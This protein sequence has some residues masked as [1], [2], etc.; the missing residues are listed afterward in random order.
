[1]FLGLKHISALCRL[2]IA[3][4]TGLSAFAGCMLASSRPSLY[5][6]SVAA[7]VL[8]LAAGASAL[9]QVQERDIDARM[10]RTRNRPLPAGLISPAHALAVA[11]VL[12]TAGSVMLAAFG[13]EPLILGIIALV[14][15]NG[16]YTPL[17]R[18]TAFAAV[19]GGFVGMIP[20]AIGWCAAGG[21]ISDPRL[22]AVGFFFFL[23]QVPHFWLQLLHHGEEY[24]SAGLPSLTARL[25]KSAVCRLTH[26]WICA[27]AVSAFL[28]PLYG[29]M[30]SQRI[31]VLLVPAA[32]IVIVAGF[33]LLISLNSTRAHVAFRLINGY[34]LLVISLLS[35][36]GL[37][38]MP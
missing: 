10:A 12:M 21:S 8:V 20:P 29:V 4:M 31:Y 5:A 32:A 17:K 6:L 27:A 22:L 7:A 36:E 18:I 11:L 13:T 25:G 23:W 15:Y 30:H 19:P 2:P 1:M 33:R 37:L 9:N 26:A 34:L 38:R 14:W 35:L 16:V 28:L 24:E 3:V